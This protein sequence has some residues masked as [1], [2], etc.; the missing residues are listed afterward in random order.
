M[1]ISLGSARRGLKTLA[2]GAEIVG[3][4]KGV[5]DAGRAVASAATAAIPYIEAAAP[6]AA[7]FI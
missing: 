1:K 4:L 2:A 5:W 6:Y 3:T 7:A